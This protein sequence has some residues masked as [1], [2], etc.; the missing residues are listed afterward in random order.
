MEELTSE[1]KRTPH[2]LPA[3]PQPFV[4]RDS[5]IQE[6]TRALLD[7]DIPIVTLVGTYG[8]GK[9]ALALEVAHRLLEQG[10]F[11]GGICGLDCR[12]RDNTLEAIFRTIQTTFGLAPIPTA[13]ESVRRYLRA[14]PC[15]LILDGY[16]AVA[17]D[18]EILAF[19]EGLPGPSK[20]LLTGGV[21]TWILRSELVIELETL[22][23]EQLGEALA[24]EDIIAIE[25]VRQLVQRV[26]NELV[27]RRGW[28][29]ADPNVLVD[30]TTK[31]LS[32]SLSAA[33]QPLQEATR[34][35]FIKRAVL[36]KYS[37]ELYNACLEDG[38]PRQQQAYEELW[39]YLYHI[40]YYAIARHHLLSEEEQI[41][42]EEEQTERAS[43]IVAEALLKIHTHLKD[44]RDPHDFLA[45]A[46]QIVL[47]EAH[48][49]YFRSVESRSRE[50]AEEEEQW[51]Q[52]TVVHEHYDHTDMYEQIMNAINQLNSRQRQVIVA[53]FLEEL[54]DNEIAQQMGLTKQNVYVLRHRALKRLRGLLE[55]LLREV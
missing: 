3:R 40:A 10:Q 12:R 9:T 6:V 27:A 23:R 32:R 7:P 38:T 46:Q 1:E 20:A 39:R 51:E 33:G 42:S 43:D 19:L 44:L 41:L 47:R 14:N 22:A 30:E 4:D 53:T 49:R 8:V 36:Q 50:L 37:R 11:A 13:R 21:R 24:T 2:N 55:P 29:L 52:P 18:L 17:Q 5:E 15:L 26:V 48:G 16:E 25:T 28:E 34:L 31:E 45:W 35:N 54:S